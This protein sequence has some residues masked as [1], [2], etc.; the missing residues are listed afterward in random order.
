MLKSAGTLGS[1]WETADLSIKPV[2]ACLFL[3]APVEAAQQ[4]S[5]E[6]GFEIGAVE[7]IEVALPA[8]A[9][10]VVC[11]PV[12]TKRHPRSGFESQFSIYHAVAAALVRGGV[13][14][15][16]V[17]EDAIADPTI[18]ALRDKVHCVVDPQADYPS[19]FTARVHCEMFSGAAISRNIRDNLGSPTRPLTDQDVVKKFLDNNSGLPPLDLERCIAMVMSLEALADIDDLLD[20]IEKI[21]PH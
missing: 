3:H 18:A 13:T 4:L 1:Y 11:D 17:G 2:P 5:R 12:E 21:V 9:F 16:E 8:Q 10:P 20:H 15:S 19:R 14:L 6:P 7:R